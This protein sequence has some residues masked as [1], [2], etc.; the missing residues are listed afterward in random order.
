MHITVLRAHDHTPASLQYKLCIRSRWDKDC[1]EGIDHGDPCFMRPIYLPADSLCTDSPP[2]VEIYALSSRP[3]GASRCGPVP[4]HTSGVP[5]RY[6]TLLME[7][8]QI[9]RIPLLVRLL[10]THRLY[11][12]TFWEGPGAQIRQLGSHLGCTSVVNGSGAIIVPLY[13][14]HITTG[15]W[16]LERIAKCAPSCYCLGLATRGQYCRFTSSRAVLLVAVTSQSSYPRSS[17]EIC[18]LSQVGIP[19]AAAAAAA[20]VDEDSRPE[21][22]NR[23]PS[24]VSRAWLPV[25][26]RLLLGGVAGRC[27][28]PLPPAPTGRTR[29]HTHEHA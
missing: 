16:S 23:M 13:H 18:A 4:L 29:Q 15:S 7:S 25:L 5:N 26:V 21:T 2:N 24:G 6:M 1:Q 22:A 27:A 14:A 17:E 3:E 19:E 10:K 11:R 28:P 20:E 9:G 12:P 8:Y